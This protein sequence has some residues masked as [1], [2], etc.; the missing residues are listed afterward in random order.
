MAKNLAS[1]RLSTSPA[2]ISKPWETSRVNSRGGSKKSQLRAKKPDKSGSANANKHTLA[3][4]TR[5]YDWL[6]VLNMPSGG[7]P[8][9]DGPQRRPLRNTI[10][11][12]DLFLTPSI[13]IF[14]R[15]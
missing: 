9:L 12:P 8:A 15:H 11:L 14:S 4:H 6:G 1:P 2:L 3:A 5:M 13:S 7:M 10:V